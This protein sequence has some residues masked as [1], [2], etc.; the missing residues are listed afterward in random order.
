VRL[1]RVSPAGSADGWQKLLLLTD[2]WRKSARC[3]MHDDRDW[4][5][6]HCTQPVPTVQAEH[7]LWIV[8]K[9]GRRAEL[10]VRQHPLGLELRMTVGD[11][12]LWSEV[13]KPGQGRELGAVAD[14]HK[15]AWLVR[16]W[17]PIGPE[18]DT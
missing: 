14:Q 17:V 11:S 12:F 13:H 4:S 18:A 1:G 15:A 16:G 6:L 2:A 8:E 5:W 7:S 9:D 3:A 10:R